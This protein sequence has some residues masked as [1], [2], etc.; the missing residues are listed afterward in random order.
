VSIGIVTRNCATIIIVAYHWLDLIAALYMTRSVP[1]HYVADMSPTAYVVL[2]LYVG[3]RAY[4]VTR[5]DR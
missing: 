5:Q 4:I 2:G 1:G 3:C